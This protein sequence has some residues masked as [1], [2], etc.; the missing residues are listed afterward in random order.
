MKESYADESWYGNRWYRTTVLAHIKFPQDLSWVH[1]LENEAKKLG[2]YEELKA[3][4]ALKIIKRLEPKKQKKIWQALQNIPISIIDPRRY[5][6]EL[7]VMPLNGT[8]YQFENR[9]Q[10]IRVN[11]YQKF[12]QDIEKLLQQHLSERILID[13]PLANIELAIENISC[14]F[15]VFPSMYN[16]S[17]QDVL[18][19]L[20][21]KDPRKQIMN[22]PKLSLR[23]FSAFF[24]LEDPASR[25]E[26]IDKISHFGMDMLWPMSL[27][28]KE[29]LLKSV[30]S[31][32]VFDEGDKKSIEFIRDLYKK[33]KAGLS[34]KIFGDNII[35]PD[36]R[37]EEIKSEKD[38]RLRAS[39]I[40]SGIARILYE[41]EGIEG[42]KRRFSCIFL[43]GK[44]Y[45]I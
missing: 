38:I 15:E 17:P 37:I 32:R 24:E 42:L 22:I 3:S 29:L 6:K 45:K 14:S 35:L 33:I 9:G 25:E 2:S 7:R 27:Y 11:R 23:L 4:F 31:K 13:S 18:D 44:K 26:T 43:M 10:K 16:F 19:S 1:Q 28:Y 8:C 34:H 30:I 41:A 40:A 20:G 36:T 21:L 12:F 39:D 5:L